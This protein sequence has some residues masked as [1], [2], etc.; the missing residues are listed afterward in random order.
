MRPVPVQADYTG[1]VQA[2]YS[3]SEH[4]I[5]RTEDVEVVLV[6]MIFGIVIL[7][8]RK[9]HRNR[10]EQKRL[11][12]QQFGAVERKRVRDCGEIVRYFANNLG[13]V[14]RQVIS[15]DE[16]ER[17]I[18]GGAEPGDL[19]NEIIGRIST[20]PG[21]IL[22]IQDAEG[23]RVPVLQPESIRDRHMYV[24]GKSGY[25]KTT[26]LRQLVYQDMEAGNGLAVIAPEQEMLTEEILPFVPDHRVDDVIYFNPA[27]LERPVVFNPLQLDEDEDLDFKAEETFAVFRR[28]LGDIGPRMEEILRHS[29]YALL[30]LGGTTLLDVGPLLDRKNNTFR[31]RVEAECKD[32]QT[33]RFFRDIFPQLPKD[34][35]LPVLNRIGRI[36]RPKVVRNCLCQPTGSLNFRQ[37]MDQGRILL[38]NLSDGI[39]GESASQ[40][41]GQLIVSK[42]QLATMSRA[43]VPKTARHRFYCYLDEFQTFVGTS[44]TSYEKILSRARKYGLGLIL[45]HQQTGQVPTDLLKEIFGNTSTLVAFQVSRSDATRIAKEFVTEYDGEI[46]STPPEELLGLRVGETYCK[47]GQTSFRMTTR[48]VEQEAD[49]RRAEQVIN[50]SRSAHGV[51]SLMDKD[52]AVSYENETGTGR[53]FPLDDIDPSEVF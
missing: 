35:T 32:E 52:A 1:S 43:D 6:I 22:G 18:D 14:A 51:A 53:G 44:A 26:L 49:H 2:L 24:V 48:M 38:F 27:D 4:P 39:L 37:A 5:E 45:A 40:L 21:V 16:L 23:I 25:G 50:L 41:L 31:K 28:S 30:E 10:E 17:M 42:L 13:Y 9:V 12:A 8:A 34:A 11:R 7:V 19:W 33:V 20:V 46:L 47:I 15:R 36:I 29:I 3:L